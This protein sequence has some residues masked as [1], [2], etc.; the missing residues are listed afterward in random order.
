MSRCPALPCFAR[1]WTGG[2]GC[3]HG[4]LSAPGRALAQNWLLAVCEIYQ[5]SPSRP[6]GPLPPEPP[7]HAAR[8]RGARRAQHRA[9]H[10]ALRAGGEGVGGGA[11][12]GGHQRRL[13]LGTPTMHNTAPPPHP[14]TL[15]PPLPTQ[16][17]LAKAF[18]PTLAPEVAHPPPLPPT[19]TTPHPTP[20][21]RSTCWPRRLGRPWR[22]RSRRAT[23]WR[24]PP[25][26][27]PILS[28]RSTRLKR[29][30]LLFVCCGGGG[31]YLLEGA[32]TPGAYSFW[33][34]YA[35]EKVRPVCVWV[36]GAHAGLPPRRAR[37]ARR[38]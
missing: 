38:G 15:S 33:P 12:Q 19:H 32:A 8:A 5:P 20:H 14:H 27:G 1:L 30:A 37:A 2:E 9:P 21:S 29:C 7:A 10:A 36:G 17:L 25:R 23:C 24:T 3:A 28:G 26:P 16:H 18:G 6:A 11:S 35:T 34:Q 31:R 4:M 13:A 22:P